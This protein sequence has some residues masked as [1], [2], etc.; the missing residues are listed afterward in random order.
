MRIPKQRIPDKEKTPQWAKDTAEAF[1]SLSQFY[2][3][4]Y[5]RD[6]TGLYDAYNGIIN[7]Q[8]YTKFLHF[9]V[10]T[11]KKSFPAEIRNFPILK[12]IVDLYMGDRR[13]RPFNFQVICAN[14][15]VSTLKQEAKSKEVQ[16]ALEQLWANFMITQGVNIGLD[17]KDMPPIDKILEVFEENYMDS[18]AIAGQHIINYIYKEQEVERKLIKG[19]FHWLVSGY[20]FSYKAA[21]EGFVEYDCVN[22]VELD[23]DMSPDVEFVE[24]GDFAIRRRF[25]HLSNILDRHAEKLTSEQVL[26]LENPSR[27]G[28][29]DNTQPIN[30]T[31]VENDFRTDR[32]IEEA[33]IVWKTRKEIIILTYIDEYGRIQEDIVT[34][35]FNLKIFKAQLTQTL[36]AHELEVRR[37]EL[38]ESLKPQ[39]LDALNA[40]VPPDATP[41]QIQQLEEQAKQQLMGVVYRVKDDVLLSQ[42]DIV[43]IMEKVAANTNIRTIWGNEVY[44]ATRLDGNIYIGMGPI[45]VQ[46]RMYDNYTSCKLPY[47]GKIYSNTNSIPISLVSIGL[48]YQ[49]TYNIYKYRMELSIA[50]SRD[51]IAVFDINMIPKGWDMNKW[52]HYVDGTGIAWVDYSKEGIKLAQNMQ[53]LLDLSIK[54]IAQYIQLLESIQIEWER[55]SGASRQRQ[56]NITQNDG[57]GTSSQSIE[58]SMTITEEL[59]ASYD[60]FAERDLQGLL[61]YGKV[62]FSTGKRLNYVLPDSGQVIYDLDPEEVSEASLGLFVAQGGK[63]AQRL[64][65]AK[66]VALELSKTGQYK[67]STLLKFLSADSYKMLERQIKKVEKASEEL[68]KQQQQVLNE[69]EANKNEIEAQKLKLEYAKLESDNL[70][71]ELDRQNKI[72]IELMK[73]EADT[74]GQDLNVNGVPDSADIEANQMKREELNMKAT[75]QNMQLHTG[76]IE[77]LNKYKEAYEVRKQKAQEHNDNVALKLKE[78]ELKEKELVIKEEDSKRKLQIAIRNKNKHDK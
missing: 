49:I 50:K 75:A 46:R 74:I 20:V 48:P 11:E 52:F 56:G 15:D 19:F 66:R 33:H 31:N 35:D 32:L 39:I 23:Y 6:I 65:E 36:I 30:R 61:D 8:Y 2:S 58:Q 25:T 13:K 64:N 7:K 27:T 16:K 47:N 21:R 73:I 18:R 71:S 60:E 55:V 53:S 45:P 5:R 9:G 26:A 22:P 38:G 77:M 54:T 41:E 68:A 59:Y 62:A 24:D 43:Y 37:M 67:G 76:M 51:V 3:S 72:D 1:F 34:G 42:S 70:N 40:N 12:P 57:L 28:L 10:T 29:L 44:E 4:Q 17:L 63:E 78:L 69:I 14:D